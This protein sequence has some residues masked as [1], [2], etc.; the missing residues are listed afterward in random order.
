VQ[1][2]GADF[3]REML[4]E[5][6]ELEAIGGMLTA[7]GTRRRTPG[8]VYFYITK[9][10]LSPELRQVIFPGFPQL[11]K[12]ITVPWEERHR[13]TNPIFEAQ[14]F[15]IMTTAPRITLFGRA[16]HIEKQ[17]NSYLM[18][19]EHSLEPVAFARG[20]PTPPTQPTLYTVYMGKEQYARIEK[21]LR[22]NPKDSII[23][24]GS[25]MWDAETNSIA[26]FA[27]TV[28]SRYFEKKWRDSQRNPAIGGDENV[29]SVILPGKPT[30]AANPKKAA[31]AEKK[32]RREAHVAR[33]QERDN[34]ANPLKGKGDT[35]AQPKPKIAT[36]AKVNGQP[37]PK[38]VP[39]PVVAPAP[40]PVEQVSS[41]IQQLRELEG[42]AATLRK[43]LAAMESKKEPGIAMTRRALDTAERQIEALRRETSH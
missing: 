24:E 3:A 13:L 25:C 18:I 21:T 36:T 34:K 27:L 5:T 23:V 19:L 1:H 38:P 8:G 7:D 39:A 17:D 41:P 2:A 26:V 37:K 4:K 43:R 20:V 33:T 31:K 42:V 9:G 35:K 11:E 40:E 14:D 16:R 6:M 12:A 30:V 22:R 10:K 28:S 15:G 29:T 32:E